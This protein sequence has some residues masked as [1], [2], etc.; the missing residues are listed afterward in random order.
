MALMN[1]RPILKTT[2]VGLL[3]F[4]LAG[5]GDYSAQKPFSSNDDN[6]RIFAE[7]AD[8]PPTVKTLYATSRLL[9]SQGRDHESSLLLVQIIRQQRDFMPAYADLAELHLKHNQADQAVSVLGE[10]LKISPKNSLLLNNLGMCHL[11]SQNYRDAFEAF[12][13]ARQAS[14]KEGR[15]VANMAVALSFEGQYDQALELYKQV[16]SPAE[17]HYNLAVLCEARQD[18]PRADLEYGIARNLDPTLQA[19]DRRLPPP[20]AVIQPVQPDKK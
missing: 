7:G 1:P 17:A 13:K 5:C 19:K 2:S 11:V 9:A 10:G 14:P 20:S 3:I 6:D 8:R 18:Y 16:V 12:Q 4:A 15:Y